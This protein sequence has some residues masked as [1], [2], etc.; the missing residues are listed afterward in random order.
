M[1][2]A[3]RVEGLEAANRRLERELGTLR[4]AA[5]EA[6]ILR[7]RLASSD[8]RLLHLEAVQRQNAELQA[9]L[10][11]LQSTLHEH[12]R[13]SQSSLTLSD[14]EKRRSQ[15]AADSVRDALQ[16]ER[17]LELQSQVAAKDLMIAGLTKQLDALRSSHKQ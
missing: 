11:H 15:A 2:A 5:E 14:N 1:E 6:M 4:T 7:E 10:D 16:H 13:S 17:L 3:G 9:R 12:R 8:A